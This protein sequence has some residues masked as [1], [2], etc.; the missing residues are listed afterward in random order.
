MTTISID[1]RLEDILGDAELS[2]V[3]GCFDREDILSELDAEDV[4][5]KCPLELFQAALNSNKLPVDTNEVFDQMFDVLI[6]NYTLAEIAT[7]LKFACKKHLID[8]FAD[9]NAEAEARLAQAKKAKDEEI[10]AIKK[11]IEEAANR[12]AALEPSLAAQ[13][14]KALPEISTLK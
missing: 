11:I 14:D 12:L 1:V 3:L 6:D 4:D 2:D 8:I 10:A 9:E 5:N 7:A 13:Y